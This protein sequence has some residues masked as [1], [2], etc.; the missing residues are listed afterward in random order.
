MEIKCRLGSSR[1]CKDA[2]IGFADLQVH[3]SRLPH[4]HAVKI[5]RLYS[6]LGFDID[7]ELVHFD[8]RF[9]D[10]TLHDLW[11]SLNHN[12]LG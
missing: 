12:A 7:K 10:K 1:G 3:P 8:L 9:M 11:Y 6:E 2:R 5:M 4:R